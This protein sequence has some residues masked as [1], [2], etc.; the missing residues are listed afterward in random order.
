MKLN[1][2][3][4][5]LTLISLSMEAKC[6]DNYQGLKLDIDTGAVNETGDV[7]INGELSVFVKCGSQYAIWHQFPES[8]TYT[9]KDLATGET[10]ISSNNELSISWN[11]NEVYDE[12]AEKPCNKIIT[13]KFTVF[14]NSIYFNIST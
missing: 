2:L 6:M 10:F 8:I 13:E 12:Y 3:V 9:L 11:G 1:F 4:A 14:L 5:G 7:V